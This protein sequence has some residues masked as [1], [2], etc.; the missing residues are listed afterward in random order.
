MRWRLSTPCDGGCQRHAMEAATAMRW[1]LPPPGDG[2]CH[3]HAMEAVNVMRLRLPPPCDGGYHLDRIRPNCAVRPSHLVPLIRRRVVRGPAAW[4]RPHLYWASGACYAGQWRE[5]EWNGSGTYTDGD[6]AVTEGMWS[7]GLFVPLW[8]RRQL[9]ECVGRT[10]TFGESIKLSSAAAQ[11]AQS[12]AVR[13]ACGTAGG[14]EGNAANG[15]ADGVTKAGGGAA[16][17]PKLSLAE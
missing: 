5:G 12:G 7:G 1:R 9:G 3:R 17:P 4:R 6:G 8:Q 2:G 16:S 13:A 10:N 14:A 11:R 15:A